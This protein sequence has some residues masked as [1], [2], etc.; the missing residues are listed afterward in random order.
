MFFSLIE[1]SRF[2]FPFVFVT[3]CLSL[4]LLLP[5]Q[6]ILKQKKSAKQIKYKSRQKAYPTFYILHHSLFIICLIL[7]LN[8]IKQSKETRMSY[9]NVKN[10]I[11]FSINI[12]EIQ[13]STRNSFL[14]CQLSNFA[15]ANIRVHRYDSFFRFILLLSGNINVNLG[16]TTVTNNSIPLNTLPFHN[17]GEIT[18]TM[19][20][21]SNSLGCCKGHDSSKWKIFLKNVWHILHLNIDSLLFKLRF[22]AKQSNASITGIVE[23]KLDSSILNS[24]LDIDEYDLIRLNHSRKGDGVACY[25]RKSLSYNRKTSFCRNIEHIFVDIFLPKSKP[26]LVGALYRP[27]EKSDFMEHLMLCYVMFC[28]AMLCYVK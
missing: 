8:K 22:I 3:V 20:S 27:P 23:S 13:D 10:T 7:L 26:I 9:N 11:F 14:R 5:K 12:F 19:S 21:E 1:L 16:P 6:I 15:L 4:I 25:I 18:P 2:V 24:E 28:Y 17:C